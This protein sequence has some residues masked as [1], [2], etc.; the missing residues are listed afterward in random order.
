MRGYKLIREAAGV[1]FFRQADGSFLITAPQYNGKTYFMTFNDIS[2]I[3][4]YSSGE[5]E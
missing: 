4:I 2:A 5:V 1:F 3:D